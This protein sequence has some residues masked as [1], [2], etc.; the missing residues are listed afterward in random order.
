MDSSGAFYGAARLRTVISKSPE[1]GA[2]RA[3]VQRFT[4]GAEQADD[5][6]L[7][8]VRWNGPR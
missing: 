7:L 2:V 3:D 1:V 8:C 6:T 4:G 5:L